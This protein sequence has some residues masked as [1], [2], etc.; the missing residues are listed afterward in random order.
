MMRKMYDNNRILFSNK[1]DNDTLNSYVYKDGYVL[2]RDRPAINHLIYNDYVTRKKISPN[3]ERKQ[4]PF[5]TAKDPFMKRRRSFAYRLDSELN[6]LF[7][8]EYVLQ[9][10]KA[11]GI[12]SRFSVPFQTTLSRGNGHC[13]I[14]ARREFDKCNYL[15]TQFGCQ[16]AT[17]AEQRSVNDIL[18]DGHWIWYV[19]HDFCF[20]GK[21]QSYD[22]D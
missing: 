6:L 21:C 19:D 2:V 12:N 9:C 18:A 5:A 7:D 16:G 3:D 11:T 13:K 20:R 1:T 4:C 15:S 8:A 22:F 17:T 10:I 14:Y